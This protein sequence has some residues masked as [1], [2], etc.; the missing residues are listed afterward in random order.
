[1]IEI[2]QILALLYIFASVIGVAYIT[3]DDYRVKK[4]Q[5]R[6]ELLDKIPCLC[7]HQPWMH[8]LKRNRCHDFVWEDLCK[9][10]EYRMDNLNYLEMLSDQKAK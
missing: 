3:Y 9:C 7:G 2:Y 5:K 10:R 1:M 8:G 6:Q 4:E